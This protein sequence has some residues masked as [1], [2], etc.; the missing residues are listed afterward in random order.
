VDS[1]KWDDT[2]FPFFKYVTFRKKLYDSLAVLQNDFDQRTNYYNNQRTHSGKY[3]F[4]KTPMKT[5]NESI[6]L[7]RHKM[8]DHL[9]R[10]LKYI[11]TLQTENP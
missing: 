9:P 7:A 8:L 2:N 11:L 3:C 4:G 6:A 10:Q 5:F 1:L